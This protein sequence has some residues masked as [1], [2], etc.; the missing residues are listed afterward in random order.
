MALPAHVAGCFAAT[1]LSEG[2][3]FD[4]PLMTSRVLVYRRNP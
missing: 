2:L 4:L 1:A 3:T